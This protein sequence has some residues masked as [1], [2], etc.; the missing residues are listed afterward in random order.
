MQGQSQAGFFRNRAIKIKGRRGKSGVGASAVARALSVPRML[1][2]A[3]SCPA[4]Q[5]CPMLLSAQ[6]ALCSKVSFRELTPAASSEAGL[7]SA[8]SGTRARVGC[9]GEP[10]EHTARPKESCSWWEAARGSQEPGLEGPGDPKTSPIPLG[11]FGVPA[12]SHSALPR[13]APSRR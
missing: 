7:L 9:C 13:Q 4:L 11:D 10:P 8:G 5:G 12:S 2:S 3:M 1:Q 6:T